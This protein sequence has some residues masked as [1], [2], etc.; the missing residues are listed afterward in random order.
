MGVHSMGFV[1]PPPSIPGNEMDDQMKRAPIGMPMMSDGPGYMDDMDL[2]TSMLKGD[3]MHAPSGPLSPP[4]TVN[5]LPPPPP[6]M[7][8]GTTV[9]NDKIS[10]DPYMAAEIASIVHTLSSSQLLYVCASMKSFLNTSPAAARRFLAQNPQVTYALL[11]TQF[12]LGSA[13]NSLL[14]LN[15]TD[16]A[17]AK[18]NRA[19]RARNEEPKQQ[20]YV[21]E[22][23]SYQMQA[24]PAQIPIQA[25]P[26]APIPVPP[27]QISMPPQVTM[28]VPAAP[29]QLPMP[30]QVPIQVP[31]QVPVQVPLVVVGQEYSAEGYPPQDSMQYMDPY[32]M[33]LQLQQMQQLVPEPAITIESLIMQGVKPAP[34]KLVDGVLKN[35]EIFTNIQRSTMAEMASWPDEQR[36]QVLSIKV[37]LHMKGIGVITRFPATSLLAENVKVQLYTSLDK[38]EAVAFNALSDSVLVVYPAFALD[39]D[40]ERDDTGI[41]CE[42]FPEKFLYENGILKVIFGCGLKHAFGPYDAYE[43]GKLI[44]KK[45]LDHKAKNL[46]VDMHALDAN[47]LEAFLVGLFVNLQTI[48]FTSKPP[49]DVDLKNVIVIH[50]SLHMSADFITRCKAMAGGVHLAREMTSAPANI[51]NTV[52]ISNFLENELESLGLKFQILE[53]SDCEELEMGAY[54]AV[55]QGSRYPPKFLHATYTGAGEIKSRIAFVGKGILFDSGGYNMKSRASSIELMKFDM[56]GMAAVFGAAKVIAQLKPPNVKVHFISATC[57]NMVDSES[58]RPGDIVVASNGKTIEIINTDAEGRLTLADALVYAQNLRVDYIVDIATLTGGC[59]IAL[60]E[61]V[62]GYFCEDEKVTEKYLL[63]SFNKTGELFWKLPIPK[64]YADCMDSKVADMVNASYSAKHSTISAAVFLKKFVKGKQWIHL[65]I[66]G[67]AW[68]SKASLATGYGVRTLV[69]FV[70][71]VSKCSSSD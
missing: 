64:Q 35:A 48:G 34:A 52:S 15:K 20:Q 55:A 68:D 26:Q 62:A 23:E 59:I 39:A 6:V 21:P 1:P 27:T 28:Q 38:A 63:E 22:P 16:G 41:S 36:Q 70:Y 45:I 24:P 66:A 30:V 29:S 12:I 69:E 51:A 37:A 11:H 47:E 9:Y 46:V 8:S 42:E 18:V 2:K 5:H 19:E 14:P 44:A 13:D 50:P 71:Q 17:I 53:C 40:E 31:V 33:Q 58:Y 32:Q 3:F 60:G 4:Y 65:D 43:F 25:P 57:E 10:I 67:A 7:G 56:G 54:L 49:K 61:L